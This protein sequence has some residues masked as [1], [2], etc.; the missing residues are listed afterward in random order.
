[1]YVKL[2]FASGSQKMLCQDALESCC[3][4]H[5]K[6]VNKESGQSNVGNLD[7]GILA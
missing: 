5:N 3:L 6:D 1:M 7:D 2:H 4:S